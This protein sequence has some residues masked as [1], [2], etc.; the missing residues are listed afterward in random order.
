MK[1]TIYVLEDNPEILEI[2][3]IILE[4]E[5]Y[6]IKGFPTVSE[7]MSNYK[8]A[9]PSLYLLDVMLP[10]GNGLDVCSLIKSDHQIPVII[11]TANSQM[12][13]MRE[14]CAA[15]FFIAKPFDI[16]HLAQKINELIQHSQDTI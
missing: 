3:S 15:D 5:G 7:F 16:D 14:V 4:A 1:N 2:I 9:Q 11:M 13:K 10:D 12:E 6:D 8:L